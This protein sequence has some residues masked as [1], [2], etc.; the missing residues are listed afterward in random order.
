MKIAVIKI[1]HFLPFLRWLFAGAVLVI[2][3][4]IK[5]SDISTNDNSKMKSEDDAYAL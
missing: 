3:G 2:T 1:N 5:T 4:A